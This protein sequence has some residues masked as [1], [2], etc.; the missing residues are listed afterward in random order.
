MIKDRDWSKIDWT[1]GLPIPRMFQDH[2][3]P[4]NKDKCYA[5]SIS[6]ASLRDSSGQQIPLKAKGASDSQVYR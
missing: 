6:P 2:E 5:M 1:A 3:L 4:L